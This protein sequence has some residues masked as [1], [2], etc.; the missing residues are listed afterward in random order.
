M[1]R[2]LL[3]ILLIFPLTTLTIAQKVNFA[4]LSSPQIGKQENQS[5]FK[6]ILQQISSLKELEFAIILGNLTEN[7]TK[8]EFT[9]LRNISKNLKIPLYVLPGEAD[10]SS[11]LLSEL[12]FIEVL[13]DTRFSITR[14][15]LLI[16]GIRT[17]QNNTGGIPHISIEDR[18]WFFELIDENTNHCLLI[19]D[20]VPE[21]IQNINILLDGLVEKE[22]KLIISAESASKFSNNSMVQIASL[23]KN[24]CNK[25]SINDSVLE[26]YSGKDFFSLKKNVTTEFKLPTTEVVET[27]QTESEIVWQKSINYSVTANPVL[28]KNRIFVI[29]KLGLIYAFGF[30][31]KQIWQNDLFGDVI[32]SGVY[33]D[34]FFA[35]ATLQGDLSTINSSNGDLLQTI[36]FNQAITTDLITFNYR[37]RKRLMIPK[38]TNS[39][40]VVLAG[41]ES[42]EVYC[43]D[44][45]T[46]EQIW[47]NN[48]SRFAVIG[49]PVYYN[50]KIF[51]AN[52]NNEIFC[53]DANEGWLIW[54][55]SSSKTSTENALGGSLLVGNNI[56]FYASSNG[57]IYSVDANLGKLLWKNEKIDASKGVSI[58]ADEKTLYLKSSE[59][60]FHILNASDGKII[61]SINM[62]YGWDN[63][64]A[65]ALEGKNI[66]MVPAS[67]G[68][69]Y[70]INSEY[71][72]KTIF[73]A[74]NDPII[75]I[76]HIENEPNNYFITTADGNL[77]KIRYEE[78]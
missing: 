8:Q 17:A 72:Y 63:S 25:F 3:Y 55:W 10:I 30:N 39:N 50:D 29:D 49:K 15:S 60:K 77:Y 14:D 48:S 12:N 34:N 69:V 23:Q 6:N 74:R 4:I 37:G 27:E 51:F 68:R 33:A 32:S 19:L 26:T 56:L 64:E 38:S 1:K 66:I 24:L 35:S 40:A 65:A 2:F 46:L 57:N 21:K 5:I 62:R 45:E 31:G 75:S 78:E 22:I 43:L 52:I 42:G 76:D 59:D 67:N 61:K 7:G 73:I 11:N 36:G 18:N 41:T 9:N 58:S 20:N 71:L 53:I 13:G 54:K 70:R 28:S 47:K 16:C 44:I